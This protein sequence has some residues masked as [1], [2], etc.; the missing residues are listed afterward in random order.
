MNPPPPYAQKDTAAWI[1]FTWASFFISNGVMFFGIYHAPVDAWIKGFLAMGTLFI[2]G[3]SLTLAK[4]LRDNIESQRAFT[5]ATD[6]KT[7]QIVNSY[8]MRHV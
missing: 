2:V 1:F 4:T 6:A 5:R 8:E 3:S 7:E